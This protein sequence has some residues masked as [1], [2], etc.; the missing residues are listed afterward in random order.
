MASI[1]VPILLLFSRR[2]VYVC[3]RVLGYQRVVNFKHEDTE[4]V[5]LAYFGSIISL[6]WMK[7]DYLHTVFVNVYPT[8][9]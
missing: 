8:R 9:E 4:N 3:R 7:G 1:L 6:G 5:Y 2:C